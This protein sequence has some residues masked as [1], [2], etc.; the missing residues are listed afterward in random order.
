MHCSGFGHD[1][2]GV[3]PFRRSVG[4]V[5]TLALLILSVSSAPGAGADRTVSPPPAPEIPPVIRDV[6]AG[7]SDGDRID[8]SLADRI[9]STAVSRD[10]SG[11]SYQRSSEMV[12]VELIFREPITQHQIDAFIELGGQIDY[13]YK[14]I[15]YGWSARIAAAAVASLPQRMGAAL[16]Q[17]TPVYK[18]QFAMD[19]A[20]QTGRVRPIWQPGFAGSET[21][22]YGD[23]NTTVAI[24][25]SGVDAYHPDLADRCVFWRDVSGEGVS[26]PIDYEGHG[27]AVAGVVVGTGRTGGAQDGELRYTYTSEKLKWSHY[28]APIAIGPGEVSVTSQAYWDG[29]TAWLEHVLWRQGTDAGDLRWIGTGQK[30]IS[31]ASYLNT[32]E[33]SNE[34]VFSAVLVNWSYLNLH[35]VVITNAVSRYPCV[36]DGYNTFSGVAPGCNWAAVKIQSSDGTG[37]GSGI[38]GAL[39]TLVIRRIKQNIKIINISMALY[40]VSGLPIRDEAVRDKVTSAIRNGIVVVIAAG[41]GADDETEA[42]RTMADPAATAMAITVG[43]SNDENALTVYSGYGFTDP[44]GD[45]AEDFKPDVVAPGGSYYHTG[46]MTVD[47]GSTDIYPNAD[48]QPEDYVP[49][50]GTSFASPFV[51]GCAAL[52]IEAMAK[53]GIEWDFESDEHPR[54]VKMLLCATA[55]E[56]NAD[57][58][59][60]LF[61]PT[62]ERASEGPEGFPVAKDR[63]EGYGLVNPDAAVEAVSLVYTAEETAVDVLS[64]GATDRRVWAR[65]VYLTAGREFEVSL[66]TPDKGDFDLYLY[67][68]VPSETGTPVIL[69]SST[70]AGIDVDESIAYTPDSDM[71]AFLVVKRVSGGGRLEL[72]PDVLSSGFGAKER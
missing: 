24:I 40:N 35:P 2:D 71:K 67:S 42:E 25:D 43:A 8:D 59:N 58:E 68:A 49:L 3:A 23:P 29:A 5:L 57:R 53:Q 37:Y 54:Y 21:G 13:V 16:A 7:D 30:G 36:G 47:S 51:A 34:E 64:H 60:G 48:K 55:S 28:S 6:Y 72:G 20:T 56:T 22:F 65:T 14:A 38:S 10:K 33:V 46:I 18:A 66:K 52:V 1:A 26:D 69:A 15:S 61:N 19:V 44:Q 50:T 12:G 17:V 41:N 31:N 62:L 27:T 32:L 39:D 9:A 45:H 11:R 4:L 63:Y 70:Q